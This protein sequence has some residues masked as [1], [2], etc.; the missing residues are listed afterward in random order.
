MKTWQKFLLIE[1]WFLLGMPLIGA[2][3][4]AALGAPGAFI[5]LALF[6]L[7]GWEFFAYLHYRYCRQEEFLA[8]LQTATT[9]QAPLET[10]LRAYLAD[11]PREHLYRGLLLTFVFPGYYWIHLRRSFDQRLRQLADML[12]AGHPLDRALQLI[13]GLATREVALA[14]TLG[15]FSGRL[16]QALAKLPD[17]RSAGRWLEFVPRLI[18]PFMVLATMVGIMSWT[19]IFIIPKMEM[20]FLHFKLKLPYATELFIAISRW[21]DRYFAWPILVLFGLALGN[22]LVVSSR[23]RWHC[24]GIAWLYRMHTRG[25][26]LQMLG[27]MLETRMPLPRVLD[28]AIHSGLLPRAI[29]ERVDLL[30]ADIEEGQPL[31]ESLVREGLLP[32]SLQGLAE[33]AQKAN[34]LPWA[35]QQL[36]DTLVRRAYQLTH[37]ML[38]IAFPLLV[39]AISLLVGAVAIAMFE[40]LVHMIDQVGTTK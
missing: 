17:R 16:P 2:A 11:R 31:P 26:F 6:V 25:Q 13:P 24:P 27:L 32:R 14:V 35:L 10:T 38:M 5:E 4:A 39:V 1:S 3:L 34:N 21:N 30:A 9:T 37:R 15:Q 12:E 36:G 40:P 28:C 7:W 20:I 19:T 29:L 33:T 8:I 23:A 18:Y 22:L